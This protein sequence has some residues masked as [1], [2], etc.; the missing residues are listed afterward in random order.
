MPEGYTYYPGVKNYSGL[1]RKA[2]EGELPDCESFK[3]LT[4]A[5]EFLGKGGFIADEDFDDELWGQIPYSLEEA[6][7]I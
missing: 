2:G 1:L 3:Y 5:G 4:V 7:G 6:L